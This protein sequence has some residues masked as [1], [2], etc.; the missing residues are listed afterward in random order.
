MA[1]ILRGVSFSVAT[2]DYSYLGQAAVTPL[3]HIRCLIALGAGTAFTCHRAG[4]V[5]CTESH[6]VKAVSPKCPALL[7]AKFFPFSET[8]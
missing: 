7:P 5:P 3:Y 6:W 2:V 4:T 1:F 8:W